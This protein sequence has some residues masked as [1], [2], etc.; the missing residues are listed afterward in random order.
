[1]YP[2]P[3]GIRKQRVVEVAGAVVI[4]VLSGLYIFNEPLK[5]YHKDRAGAGS[6]DASKV[7]G[8]SPD[9]APASEKKE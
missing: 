2:V 6:A 3:R 5:Q 4:G 8:S 9:S 7:P 1:M